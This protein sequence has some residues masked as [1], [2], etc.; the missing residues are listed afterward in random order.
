MRNLTY[1]VYVTMEAEDGTFTRYLYLS[2]AKNSAKAILRALKVVRDR[3]PDWVDMDA[4]LADTTYTGFSLRHGEARLKV[5]AF[6][7]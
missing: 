7:R 1:P 5:V 6:D 4:R 3:R 2:G